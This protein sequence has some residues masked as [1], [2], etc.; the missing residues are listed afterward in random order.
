MPLSLLDAK[1][2][3]SFKK[4]IKQQHMGRKGKL[5]QTDYVRSVKML[6]AGEENMVLNFKKQRL[7]EE[8]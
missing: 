2:C 1:L 8:S 5:K 4:I 3:F 6:N 7:D